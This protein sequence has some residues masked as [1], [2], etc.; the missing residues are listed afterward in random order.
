MPRHYFSV[1]TSL[2]NMVNLE[3][4]V[5]RAPHIFPNLLMPLSGPVK[6]R[7][8]SGL[9]RRDGWVMGAWQW[10]V[11]TVTDWRSL[12]ANVMGG[13]SVASRTLYISTISEDYFYSPFL[14]VADKPYPADGMEPA[15][16]GHDV[17]NIRMLLIKAVLQSVTK[18][19]NYTVTTSDRLVYGNTASGNITLTLPAAASVTPNTVYSFQKTNA[20]NTLTLDGNASETIDGATTKALTALNSRADLVSDG[21]NWL[22]TTV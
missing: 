17:K 5:A 9:A 1:G 12:I 2:A 3:T 21:S 22:S 14:V 8:G 4:Y 7:V 11:L 18:T 13:Y 10:D 6:T 16:G 20:S 19:A 15:I